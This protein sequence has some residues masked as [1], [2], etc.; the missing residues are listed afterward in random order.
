MGDGA[1]NGFD[2]TG[3]VFNYTARVKFL[4]SNSG[5]SAVVKFRFK[6]IDA[7]DYLKVEGTVQGGL[8]GFNTG[9]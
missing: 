7:F 5:K 2:I 9:N 8:I 3:G 1:K 4:G 6:G